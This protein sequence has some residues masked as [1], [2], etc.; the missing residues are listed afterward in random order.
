LI[1]EH[2]PLEINLGGGK[3]E[4]IEGRE[5]VTTEDITHQL[6]YKYL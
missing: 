2:L 6:I 1:A 4:L 3:G 5:T